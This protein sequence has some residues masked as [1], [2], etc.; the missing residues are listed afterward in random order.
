MSSPADLPRVAGIVLAAGA[1][2]RMGEN[3]MLLQLDGEPLARRAARHAVEAGLD[4][5]TVVVGRDAADVRAAIGDLPCEIVLN[6]GFTGPSSTSLHLALES[7]P[8]TIEAAIVILGDMIG[9][10]ST[11]IRAVADAAIAYPAPLVVSRYG[12][13]TAPPLLFRRSLF[14]EL[15]AWTGEGCGKAVVQRHAAEA[16]YLD[17]PPAALV[18]VDTRE[19]WS[20]VRR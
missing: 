12:D 15:L 16:V 4:P 8:R 19:A 17:W 3:K 2:R 14:P 7:L 13:V 5:V 20:R 6:E 1:A 10:T 11:M 18:D 9:V